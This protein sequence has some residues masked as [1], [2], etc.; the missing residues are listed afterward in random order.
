MLWQHIMKERNHFPK[1]VQRT[2]LKHGVNESITFLDGMLRTVVHSCEWH[3]TSPQFN[4]TS[5]YDIEECCNRFKKSD[6]NELKV[7]YKN[8]SKPITN[9]IL[10]DKPYHA[11]V[12]YSISTYTGRRKDIT[13]YAIIHKCWAYFYDDYKKKI[14]KMRTHGK[15]F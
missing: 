14:S 12:E 4:Q 8:Q 5:F 9:K 6:I 10:E 11:K 13:Q 1:L 15:H 2:I 7:R 3:H